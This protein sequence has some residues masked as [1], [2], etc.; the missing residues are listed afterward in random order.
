MRLREKSVGWRFESPQVTTEFR[1]SS[2]L[3][4]RV[5]NFVWREFGVVSSQNAIHRRKALTLQCEAS[6]EHAARIEFGR[7]AM[8]RQLKQQPVIQADIYIRTS[9][10]VRASELTQ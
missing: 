9:P 8:T 6:V 10:N 4:D 7:A 3:A 1:I 5:Q 2:D